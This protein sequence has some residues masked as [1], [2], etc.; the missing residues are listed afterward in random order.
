VSAYKGYKEAIFAACQL[1]MESS[2]STNGEINIGSLTD[3]ATGK[4]RVNFAN[5]IVGLGS[6]P[7]YT[8][9][10]GTRNDNSSNGWF[11][12]IAGRASTYVELHSWR[13]G[14][15]YHD[16]DTICVQC[17]LGDQS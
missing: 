12:G 14:V 4:W 6:A 7:P 5:A 13:N 1:N 3:L 2:G 15:G 17:V 10:V 8:V 16:V 9:T 11:I